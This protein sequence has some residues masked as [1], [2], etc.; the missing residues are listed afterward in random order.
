M[1][2][3]YWSQV[4]KTEGPF[5]YHVGGPFAW[6]ENVDIQVKGLGELNP[7]KY[8]PR[9]T[10]KKGDAA[11]EKLKA[12]IKE[13]DYVEPIIWNKQ[14]GHVVG[15]HQRLQVLKDLGFTEAHVSVV[16]MDDI[17]EAALN[18]ALNKISGEWD[19]DKLAALFDDLSPTGLSELTGFDQDEIDGL[20]DN[21]PFSDKDP[22]DYPEPYLDDDGI[23]YQN[24]YG[25][26]VHVDSE[27]EQQAVYE[28]LTS[29]GYQCK[30]VVV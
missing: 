20:L 7:A 14:T 1:S 15:G 27:L 25:V 24:Q 4:I 10:L 3:L 19:E 23:N 17:R 9:K 13:F 22:D 30:V 16:D 21:L 2:M 5:T 28:N 26:I 12:S 8:N 11:Y 29:M 6:G 18:L